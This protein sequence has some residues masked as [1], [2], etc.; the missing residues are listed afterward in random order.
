MGYDTIGRLRDHP[1]SSHPSGSHPG[2]GGKETF[3]EAVAGPHTVIDGVV[4]GSVEK[5]QGSL[6]TANTK[7]IVDVMGN[8]SYVESAQSVDSKSVDTYTF[9]FGDHNSGAR[10]LKRCVR[11]GAAW[12]VSRTAKIV[13]AR[14]Y[15]VKGVVSLKVVNELAAEVARNKIKPVVVREKGIAE[16]VT[17][18]KFRPGVDGRRNV[19]SYLEERNKRQEMMAS[20]LQEE[21]YELYQQQHMSYTEEPPKAAHDDTHTVQSVTTSNASVGGGSVAAAAVARKEDLQFGLGHDSIESSLPQTPSVEIAVRKKNRSS[22]P[23]QFATMGEGKVLSP[24]KGAAPSELFKE[25]EED[26][27]PKREGTKI[28]CDHEMCRK[29]FGRVEEAV[30]WSQSSNKTFCTYCWEL[31][32]SHQPHNL[33]VDYDEKKKEIRAKRAEKKETMRE[34]SIVG[35]ESFV[36][37]TSGFYESGLSGRSDGQHNGDMLQTLNSMYNAVGVK[38][39]EFVEEDHSDIELGTK[40]QVMGTGEYRKIEGVPQ[41]AT[42]IRVAAKDRFGMAQE[43][44][45]GVNYMVRRG[46]NYISDGSLKTPTLHTSA[47]VKISYMNKETTRG[48]KGMKTS[49]STPVLTAAEA[50]RRRLLATKKAAKQKRV[51]EKEGVGRIKARAGERAAPTAER[52]RAEQ[53]EK[54]KRGL[55]GQSRPSPLSSTSNSFLARLGATVKTSAGRGKD[56]LVLTCTSMNASGLKAGGCYAAPDYAVVMGGISKD[57]AFDAAA[58]VYDDNLLRGK[59][60]V[61]ERTIKIVHGVPVYFRDADAAMDADEIRRLKTQSRGKSGGGRAEEEGL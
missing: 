38:K 55:L 7:L 3:N 51:E 45:N 9:D 13:A 28:W 61:K 14:G 36:A 25:E 27:E 59:K 57:V 39:A 8:H 40:R 21:A 19:L 47:K 50:K 34:D 18:L 16:K 58:A 26:H 33:V 31:I 24:Q 20:E 10:E 6:G 49:F 54:L 52:E 35:E 30:F 53:S 43:V 44:S 5:P 48:M 15:G 60:T 46:K 11:K 12:N 37:S 29:K 17:M 22:S 32:S 1:S 56:P 41:G 23:P 42:S 4:D 2:N